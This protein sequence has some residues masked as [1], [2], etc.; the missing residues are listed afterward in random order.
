MHADAHLPLLLFSP[1]LFFFSH[2]PPPPPFITHSLPLYQNSM[3]MIFYAHTRTTGYANATFP[4]PMQTLRSACFSFFL[5]F[6]HLY[7]FS[8]FPPLFVPSHSNLFTVLSN[9]WIELQHKNI[10]QQQ[11]ISCARARAPQG[12]ANATSPSRVPTATS[13]SPSPPSLPSLRH[14]E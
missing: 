11:M 9:L 2:P 10:F 5:S 3:M 1:S 14:A 6:S 12:Y 7:S 8:Y 4:S 13:A